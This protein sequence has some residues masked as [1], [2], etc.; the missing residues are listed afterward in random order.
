M[1]RAC[2]TNHSKWHSRSRV[3]AKKFTIVKR[4]L[5]SSSI[6]RNI[7][8]GRLV[9]FNVCMK[10]S[11]KKVIYESPITVTL[12]V[13]PGV[14]TFGQRPSRLPFLRAKCDKVPLWVPS[15]W[16]KL[17]D[18]VFSVI[19]C[20]LRCPFSGENVVKC[21]FLHAGAPLIFVVSSPQTSWVRHCFNRLLF[22]V[23]VHERHVISMQKIRWW[24][25]E[26]TICRQN[27]LQSSYSTIHAKRT[28]LF[29]WLV[30]ADC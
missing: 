10:E 15:Q 19:K 20:P 17:H 28:L 3:W 16:R 30:S 18:V 4:E 13:S 12:V 5:N 29:V 1:L 7:Y 11:K 21:P 27:S 24:R 9:G 26:G 8:L 23:T 22:L 2:Q 25:L 6:A 14:P